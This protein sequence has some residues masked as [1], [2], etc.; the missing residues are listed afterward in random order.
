MSETD[1]P[2]DGA[3]RTDEC[4][5][6]ASFTDHG[7]EDGSIL[8]KTTYRL[9]AGDGEPEYEPSEEFFDRLAQ[10]FTWAYLGNVEDEEIA[11]GV[12]AAIDDARVLTAQE[13]ADVEDADL[14]T[15][16]IPAFYQR[17]AGFH[18][19]YRD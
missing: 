18:C 7:I 11:L 17:V 6:T 15:E 16:V 5:T 19:A 13:F 3:D 14:R 12:E 8:V 1:R 4:S 2:I 9:L 10:A